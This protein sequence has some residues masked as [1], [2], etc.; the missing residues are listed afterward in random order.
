MNPS[1]VLFKDE[2]GNCDF[3]LMIPDYG[4]ICFECG[5]WRFL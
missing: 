4:I 2:E 1:V 3:G 5:G